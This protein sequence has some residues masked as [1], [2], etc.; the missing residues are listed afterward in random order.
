MLSSRKR[1]RVNVENQNPNEQK[2]IDPPSVAVVEP[3][4][5]MPEPEDP[6]EIPTLTEKSEIVIQENLPTKSDAEA[7]MEV[8]QINSTNAHSRPPSLTEAIFAELNEE[9]PQDKN[10][11]GQ[12]YNV[13]PLQF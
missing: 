3:I 2:T 11:E 7:D 6:V 8:A 9:L 10:H 12:I 1:A 13:C 4:H 5:A